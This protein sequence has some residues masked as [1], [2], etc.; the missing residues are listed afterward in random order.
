MNT[1][2]V[3][4][5][6][7]GEPGRGVRFATTQWGVVAAA[8]DLQ[9]PGGREALGQLLQAYWF[10]LYAQVRRRGYSHESAEDLTQGFL[11]HLLSRDRLGRA[12]PERGRFRSFLLA[13]LTHFLSND[14]AARHALKRGG[15]A[16]DQ[17][18]PFAE[19][20]SRWRDRPGRELPPDRAFDLHWA[21]ILLD[22]VLGRLRR[23]MASEGRERAFEVLKP[24]LVEGRPDS[25]AAEAGMRL[26]LTDTATRMAVH[27]L[28]QRYRVLIREEIARTLLDPRQV[29]DELK[30]LVAALRD[31]PSLEG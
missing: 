30:A 28:R 15:A 10:P 7:G 5:G 9:E 12:D 11:Q 24:F 22:L 18:L 19:G 29:E 8:G 13:S 6:V 17:G 4:A 23:E 16:V 1:G 26:G 31:A 2:G 14:Y 25:S 3:M 20:D 21:L 27:R